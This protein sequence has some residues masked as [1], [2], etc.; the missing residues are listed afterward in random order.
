L[1]IK[2]K[3][4][5]LRASYALT[6]EGFAKAFEFRGREPSGHSQRVVELSLRLAEKMGITGDELDNIQHGALL[7]DI[8]ILSI[9]DRIVLKQGTLNEEEKVLIQKHPEHARD[10]LV[11]IP[12]L[13]NCISIPYCHH[14]NWDGSGYPQGLKGEEIPLHARLFILVDHWEE[15]SSDRPYRAAWQREKVLSYIQENSGKIYDPQITSV[16]LNLIESNG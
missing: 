7:H 12:Y 10:L 5:E 1:W 14:E 3:G 16:F 15:L 11:K 9:P 2:K 6:L 4:A 8:G 13:Q